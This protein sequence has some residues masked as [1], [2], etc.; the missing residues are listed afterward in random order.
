MQVNNVS[1]VKNKPKNLSCLSSAQTNYLS[2]EFL[3][4][5]LHPP[6][7][8]VLVFLSTCMARFFTFLSDVQI[9]VE[10]TGRDFLSRTAGVGDRETNACLLMI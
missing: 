7:P 4:L 8:P 5:P 6:L 10:K 9:A 1:P 2:T 3:T